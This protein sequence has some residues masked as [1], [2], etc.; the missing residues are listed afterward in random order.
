MMPLD[1]EKW[2]R[3]RPRRNDEPYSTEAS[4]FAHDF[5]GVHRAFIDKQVKAA[6]AKYG[7]RHEHLIQ[8]EAHLRLLRV[9]RRIDLRA[10]RQAMGL[11]S[12]DRAQDDEIVKR[13]LSSTLS[14]VRLSPHRKKKLPVDASGLNQL[15]KVVSFEEMASTP[16][17]GADTRLI[18]GDFEVAKRRASN[19]DDRDQTHFDR[20]T[21]DLWTWLNDVSTQVS[22]S[23][24]VDPDT[25]WRWLMDDGGP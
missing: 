3:I 24:P 15:P 13:F 1:W 12:A 10:R 21:P 7:T 16:R 23:A 4:A 22:A 25:T 18:D 19:R 20:R 9:L 6:V 14:I 5:L 11:D 17:A 2:E 8:S